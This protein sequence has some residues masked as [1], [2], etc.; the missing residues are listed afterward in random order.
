MAQ[1]RKP[2]QSLD[3]SFTQFEIKKFLHLLWFEE[4]SIIRIIIVLIGYSSNHILSDRINRSIL[5]KYSRERKRKEEKGEYVQNT[6]IFEE[7]LQR[8]ANSRK[9][10]QSRCEDK[11]FPRAAFSSSLSPLEPRLP[12]FRHGEI[13]DRRKMSATVTR[14]FLRFEAKVESLSRTKE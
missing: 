9:N 1:H 11:S 5:S 4:K 12:P 6:S 3:H 2:Q 14:H 8:F 13:R 10:A 7:Y